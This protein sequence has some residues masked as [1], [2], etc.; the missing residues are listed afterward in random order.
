[1]RSLPALLILVLHTMPLP[2][3]AEPLDDVKQSFLAYKTAILAS[4]GDAAADLVTQG[5]RNYYRALAEHA[6]T[7]DYAGLHRLHVTDRVTTMLLRQSLN[8][9]QLKS[10]SGSEVV[11]YAVDQ[12]W[13]G[14]EGAAQLQLGNY[15]ID[16]VGATGIILRPDG[17]ETTFKMEFVK[18]DGRWL[19][20]LLA[21][22][23]LTRTAFEYS[24][25]Q[26]GLT[27]DQFILLMLEYSTGRKPGPSI[28]TPPL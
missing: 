21:L 1:M 18:E 27:E 6:L 5:S 14:K 8:R 19:L 13:I 25:K 22:M 23:N 28:W 7:L 17:Q 16:G 24:I 12:G 20:D 26:S 11:S 10:M 9:D 2:A 15:R 3:S 4:D